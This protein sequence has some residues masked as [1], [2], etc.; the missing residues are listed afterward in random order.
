MINAGF[1][2]TIYY[3]SVGVAMAAVSM[4]MI[5]GWGAQ[6]HKIAAQRRFM[7]IFGVA[8]AVKHFFVSCFC[9]TVPQ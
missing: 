6:K 3:Y 2:L 1:L 4:P 9:L 7:H 8:V 5:D